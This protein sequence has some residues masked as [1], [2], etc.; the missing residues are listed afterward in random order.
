MSTDRRLIKNGAVRVRL[1]EVVD[2]RG[3]DEVDRDARE[4]EVFP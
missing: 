3:V 2:D 4:A 1:G